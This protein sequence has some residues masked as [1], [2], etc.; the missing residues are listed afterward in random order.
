VNQILRIHEVTPKLTIEQIREY[1]DYIAGPVEPFDG[2]E[3]APEFPTLEQWSQ[4]QPY[5]LETVL[6][7][8]KLT[9]QEE[10]F[11]FA[12]SFVSLAVLALAVIGVVHIVRVLWG[13]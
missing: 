13:N 10:F 11:L 6:T 2:T 1:Q 9:W 3:V 7:E 5:P 4:Q 12:W 8:T